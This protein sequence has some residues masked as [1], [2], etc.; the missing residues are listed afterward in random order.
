MMDDKGNFVKKIT[1]DPKTMKDKEV[2]AYR[3]DR[4]LIF[5]YESLSKK[6]GVDFTKVFAMS[7]ESAEYSQN[8]DTD[9]NDN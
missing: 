2:S 7:S 8:T 5:D 9:N 3:P 6:Y 1:T 4:P